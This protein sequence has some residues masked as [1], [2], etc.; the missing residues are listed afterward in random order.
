VLGAERLRVAIYNGDTDAAVMAAGVEA[1]AQGLGFDVV[2]DWR[3][4]TYHGDGLHM[5]GYV[6]TYAHNFWFATFR[7]SGHSVPW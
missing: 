5:G 1:W 6:T 2:E 3:P 7:G 4:W